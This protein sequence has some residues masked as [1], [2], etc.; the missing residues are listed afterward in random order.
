MRKLKE[1]DMTLS[2]KSAGIGLAITLMATSAMAD[3][4]PPPNAVPIAGSASAGCWAAGT[5]GWEWNGTSP[6]TVTPSGT[7]SGASAITISQSQL[8][9]TATYRA[10]P[11][12][13]GGG[14]RLRFPL[15]CNAPTTATLSA[16]HGRL[17]NQDQQTLPENM[18]QTLSATRSATFM[19]AYRYSTAFGFVNTVAGALPPQP[20]QLVNGAGGGYRDNTSSP[21]LT[22]TPAPIQ[23][24]TVE[25]AGD[26]ANIR[27]LDFRFQLNSVPDVNGVNGVKPVMIAGDYKETFT[28]TIAPGL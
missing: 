28:I 25:S 20:A 17:L 2:L 11:N 8:I 9:N 7:F 14:L 27:R 3:T 5:T 4:P 1:K 6:G 22:T 12:P 23:L 24:A 10:Q 15:Y 18:P 16:A 13:G 26:W 21:A 19:N